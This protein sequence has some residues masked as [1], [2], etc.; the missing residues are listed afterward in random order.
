M[1]GLP[2]PRHAVHRRRRI[3][4]LRKGSDSPLRTM[5]R[6]SRRR[7]S[8]IQRLSAPRLPRSELNVTWR[9][10]SPPS[11]SPSPGPSLEHFHDAPAVSA[12]LITK[13]YDTV[14]LGH[15]LINRI[16]IR[17]AASLMT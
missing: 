10:P 9:T 14:R 13:F 15:R 11:V 1:A 16:Q 2:P 12:Q 7:P 5:Q 17:A 6:S 3:P 4:D 8:P